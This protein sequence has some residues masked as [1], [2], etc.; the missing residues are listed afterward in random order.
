MIESMLQK[1][2]QYLSKSFPDWNAGEVLNKAMEMGK[3]QTSTNAIMT[4]LEGYANNKGYSNALANNKIWESLKGKAPDE[5]L[6]YAK[7]TIQE[8][9]LMNILS[10]FFNKK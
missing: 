1:A 3:T 7:N 5:V 6:P 10:T 4:M 2:W 9:G 8:M